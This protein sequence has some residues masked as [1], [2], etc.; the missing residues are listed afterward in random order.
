MSGPRE[1]KEGFTLSTPGMVANSIGQ[2]LIG[3]VDK[4]RDLNTRL[5]FRPYRVR[6]IRTRF[7]GPRRGMGIEAVIHETD[8]LPTPLVVDMRSLAE[9]VTAVGVE[10]NGTV[11]LQQISGRYTEEMLL[12]LGPDGSPVAP[13]E[14]VYYEI[15]FFRRDGRP[16]ERRRFLVD[17]MPMYNAAAI[18]WNVS[19]VGAGENRARDGQPTGS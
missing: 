19:L 5:G 12:G 4:T 2:K 1:K 8:I 7:S 3:V 11:Q 18:Q 6:I 16:S 13:N 15:E 10:E 17:S 14:T 9:V